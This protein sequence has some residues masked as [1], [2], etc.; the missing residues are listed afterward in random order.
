MR[1]HYRTL[2]ICVFI[3]TVS[4]GIASAQQGRSRA[5]SHAEMAAAAGG[6]ATS[7]GSDGV[8]RFIVAADSRS[9]PLG[10]TH[11]GAASRHLGRFSRAHD[12]TPADLA[13]A[14]PVGVQTLTSGDVIVEMRQRL[15]GL[16]VV[17]S[18][19][20]VLMH[21]DHRLVAISGRPRAT[22]RA[23]TRFARSPED[24]LAA[25]LSER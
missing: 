11:E 2:T 18:A 14:F 20:K 8:P 21:G 16:D 7:F 24:A 13:A 15:A 4:A 3:V 6:V 19:V 12:V 23:D 1:S 5:Q 25:A 17:G 9:G 10:E 22:N